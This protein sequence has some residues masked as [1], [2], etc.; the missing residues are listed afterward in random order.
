[1]VNLVFAFE[2]GADFVIDS[3][4]FFLRDIFGEI[5]FVTDGDIAQVRA[6]KINAATIC[7]RIQKFADAVAR[8]KVFQLGHAVNVPTTQAATVAFEI[9]R[10]VSR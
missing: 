10:H 5:F 7:Y 4:I 1:M 3:Q 6:T 9:N 8:V 2:L